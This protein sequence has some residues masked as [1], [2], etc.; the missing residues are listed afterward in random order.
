[1][2]MK[3]AEAPT[4]KKSTDRPAGWGKFFLPGPTEVLPEVL[5]AQLKPMIGHR[6]AGIKAIMERLQAG[7]QDVFRTKRSVYL[8]TSSATGLMEAGARNGVKKKALSLVN[9][10]F[11]QRYAEIVE[12]CGFECERMEV[13]WGQVFDPQQVR[14][15]LK[16]GGIDTVT[17]VH[18]E[19]S[20]GALNPI[21][22]ISKAVHEFDDVLILVDSVT[23]IG[24]A[25]AQTDR[26][27]LDWILTGSQKALALPP[28]LSFGT[29]SERMMERA[30]TA[31][32]KGVYFDLVT[33]A[34]NQK[35]FM[36]PTTPALSVMYSL[37]VQL[38]RI[39]E[40]TMEGRWARHSAMLKRC[41][42]WVDSMREDRGVNISVLA[43]AGHRSPTVTTVK[44]PEGQASPPVVAA[45][46]EKGFVIGGGYG[47]I[48]EGTFRI[49][50]M[51]DHTVDGQEVILQALTEVLTK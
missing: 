47:K 8:S 26:W 13:P 1:M 16:Q 48:K 29:A 7:L 24:G 50:H 35:D 14:E 44:M 10:A 45:M 27:N 2:E 23:G 11:S 15:R 12:S 38:K 6:G 19:T 36:T 4:S 20:T 5:E 18:S 34:K 42:E 32:N 40:E 3:T 37:D 39:K 21:G 9:G 30:K 25:E 33:F 41:G 28:G 49:G 43:P 51:G 17:V 31:R 46:K 22:E